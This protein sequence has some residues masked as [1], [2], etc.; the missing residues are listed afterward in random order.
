MKK[1]MV[2]LIGLLLLVSC[3]DGNVVL[4]TISFGDA[5]IAKCDNT[6]L[7][8]KISENQSMIFEFEESTTI[9][10][11]K[12]DVNTKQPLAIDNLK[13]K[14]IYRTYNGNPVKTSICGTILDANPQITQEWIAEY[15][16]V[17][18]KTSAILSAPNTNNATKISKFN[19][20]IV[21]RN[22][23][24]KKPDG[25]TQ[26][27]TEIPFGTVQTN[28]DY[29]LPFGFDSD[30]NTDVIKSSCDTSIFNFSG[31]ESLRLK[32]KPATFDVL[33]ATIAGANAKTALLDNDNTLT[34]SLYNNI[35]NNAFYCVIPQPTAPVL[36]QEWK[37][38]NGISDIKG[39][40]SVITTT[41]TATQFKHTITLKGVTFKRNNVTFYYGDIIEMGSF[42]TQ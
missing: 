19:H 3:D 40:I 24:W 26:Q 20:A 23:G 15:G 35:I 10:P 28:P 9:A 14:L 16:T 32:L 4:Q 37:A 13:N 41:Q 7:L 6:N 8:Y 21:F 18:I 17:E 1:T 27:E 2:L 22:V 11:F 38:E 29:N 25:S 12:N 5:T 36:L 31:S 42:V 33:F 30:A 39:T 34:Y